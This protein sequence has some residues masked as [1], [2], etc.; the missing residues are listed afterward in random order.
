LSPCYHD[1][2]SVIEPHAEDHLRQMGPLCIE[3]KL[4]GLFPGTFS[5]ARC[6]GTNKSERPQ[7]VNLRVKGYEN[8]LALEMD[9]A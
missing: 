6:S 4:V 9:A 5:V 3:A 8:I 7:H 2:N 1:L